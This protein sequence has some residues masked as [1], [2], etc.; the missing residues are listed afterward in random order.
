MKKIKF[1]FS[2]LLLAVAAS[3]AAGC[4]SNADDEEYKS[5]LPKIVNMDVRML[6][7]STVLYTGEKI[8]ATLEQGKKGKHIYRASYTWTT[9]PERGEVQ[10][11]YRGKVVYDDDNG[12]P[13]DTIVFSKPG[14]YTLKFQ[15]QYNISGQPAS[16]GNTEEVNGCEVTYKTLSSLLYSITATKTIRVVNK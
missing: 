12:N 5:R 15:G 14:N 3:I 1:V 7:G 10:H 11:Q 13:T 8:V 6:D 2:A 16:Y 4:T 9:S